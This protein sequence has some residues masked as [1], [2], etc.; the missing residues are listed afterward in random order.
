MRKAQCYCM[1]LEDLQNIAHEFYATFMAL[2]LHFNIPIHCNC[3]EMRESSTF[4]KS[5]VEESKS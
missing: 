5:P 3:R 2:L 1:A 4:L